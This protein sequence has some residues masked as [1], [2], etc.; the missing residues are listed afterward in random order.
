MLI[1]RHNDR[2]LSAIFG[3]GSF[4]AVD[5]KIGVMLEDAA[6]STWFRGAPKTAIECD[7]VDALNNAEHLAQLLRIRFEAM[8]K[9]HGALSC[10]L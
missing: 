1:P 2:D 6:G 8:M 9:K 7:P 4:D 5:R 10:T 3:E